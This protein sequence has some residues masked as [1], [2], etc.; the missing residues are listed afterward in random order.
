VSV[1]FWGHFTK[2][3]PVF[4]P[5]PGPD[6]RKNART[7]YTVAWKINNWTGFFA[8]TAKPHPRFGTNFW[9]RLRRFFAS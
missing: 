1:H 5:P 8:L 3:A 7:D 2:G 9:L 4:A 6:R